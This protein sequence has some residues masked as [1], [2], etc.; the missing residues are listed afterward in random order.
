MSHGEQPQHL[1]HLLK[2]AFWSCLPLG[3]TFLFHSR[4]RTPPSSRFLPLFFFP[5]HI[6]LC[7]PDLKTPWRQRVLLFFAHLRGCFLGGV[8]PKF[9]FSSFFFFSPIC[10][11]LVFPFGACNF[12]VCA[13]CFILLFFVP[14]LVFFNLL[15]SLCCCCFV[16]FFNSITS[17]SLIRSLCPF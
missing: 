2:T 10:F 8:L 7:F 6:L 15:I 5:S 12:C 16:F 13:L 9:D 1:N 11:G 4:R 14:G 17:P 3:K